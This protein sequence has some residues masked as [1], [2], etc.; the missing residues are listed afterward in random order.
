MAKEEKD[1][2]GVE[3]GAGRVGGDC[4][5]EAEIDYNLM[6]SFPA[7]DPPS[8]TLG[9]RP[10]KTCR[11]EFEGEKPSASDPSHQNQPPE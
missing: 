11:E 9:V 1:N 2:E 3:R 8:W 5:S 4:M 10:N 7:S 6:E